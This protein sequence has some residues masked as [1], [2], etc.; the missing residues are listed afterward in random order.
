[1]F[2]ELTT[3]TF[4]TDLGRTS[5]VQLQHTHS[6]SAVS[7]DLTHSTVTRPHTEQCY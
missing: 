6:H 3:I 5:V 1:M 2:T 4:W 7:M